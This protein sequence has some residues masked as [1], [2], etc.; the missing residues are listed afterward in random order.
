L[1]L[2]NCTEILKNVELL[3]DGKETCFIIAVTTE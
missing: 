3:E 2:F 1:T